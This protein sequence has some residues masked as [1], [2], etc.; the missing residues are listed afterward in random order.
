MRPFPLAKETLKGSSLFFLRIP[1]GR[2][3]SVARKRFSG[4]ARNIHRG[5]ATVTPA[6]NGG[7][8]GARFRVAETPNPKIALVGPKTPSPSSYQGSLDPCSYKS[9]KGI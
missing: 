2:Q 7:L 6:A 1:H 9:L 3:S 8:Q 5:G 4:I